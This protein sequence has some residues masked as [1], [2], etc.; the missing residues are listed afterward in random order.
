M[1]LVIF[2]MFGKKLFSKMAHTIVISNPS[3][4]ICIIMNSYPRNF[5]GIKMPFPKVVLTRDVQQLYFFLNEL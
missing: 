5:R 1:E 4:K 2:F 3:P